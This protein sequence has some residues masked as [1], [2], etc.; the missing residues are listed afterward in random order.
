MAQTSGR[1]LATGLLLLAVSP[2]R[3]SRHTLRYSLNV[4]REFINRNIHEVALD[5]KVRIGFVKNFLLI[6]KLIHKCFQ[7]ERE[8]EDCSEQSSSVS[9]NLIQISSVHRPV[10]PSR[11]HL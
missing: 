3:F 2:I 5:K 6:E 9:N 4:F 7:C 10:I 8:P 11:R 1:H